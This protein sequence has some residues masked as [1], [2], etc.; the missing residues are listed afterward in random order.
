MLL[1]HLGI[2]AL[3][4]AGVAGDFCVLFTAHDAYMRDFRLLVPGDCVASDSQEDNRS[5]LRHMAKACKA[6]TGPSAE[7]DFAALAAAK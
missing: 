4:L 3:V 7:I 1:R 5:A 2:R 6:A